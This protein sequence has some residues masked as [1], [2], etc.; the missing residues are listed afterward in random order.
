MKVGDK[1]V[2]ATY[3]AQSRG[4]IC[5]QL[6]N[7]D[8]YVVSHFEREDGLTWFYVEGLDFH[9]WSVEPDEDGDSYKQFFK[10]LE[11]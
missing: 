8:E 10:H 11:G 2:A 6:V 5:H 7:G 1:L 9:R 3:E 4:L